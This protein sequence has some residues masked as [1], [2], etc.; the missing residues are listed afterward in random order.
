V[1]PGQDISTKVLPSQRQSLYQVGL[2]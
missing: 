1:G 2:L